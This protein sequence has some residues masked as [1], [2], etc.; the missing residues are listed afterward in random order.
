MPE[1]DALLDEDFIPLD[2]AADD[3]PFDTEVYAPT[4]SRTTGK[5]EPFSLDW[6]ADDSPFD[7]EV[8]APT[9]SRMTRRPQPFSKGK[10]RAADEMEADSR[11]S[12]KQRFAAES[13]ATP[14]ATAVDWDTC[15]TAEDMS[16]CF[17]NAHYQVLTPSG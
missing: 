10:K 6:A 5:P 2:W 4:S 3:S 13:R 7:T 1:R 16:V 17:R 11:Y 12:K 9:S 15:G 14:W 8:Y